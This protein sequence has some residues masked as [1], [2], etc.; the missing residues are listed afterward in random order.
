MFFF[1]TKSSERNRQKAT[2]TTHS[3]I[4]FV[5]PMNGITEEDKKKQQ[6]L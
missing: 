4:V 2:D 1:Y 3:S 5:Q 6:Q